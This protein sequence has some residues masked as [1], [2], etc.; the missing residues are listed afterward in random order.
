MNSYGFTR[1][2]LASRLRE[3][4]DGLEKQDRDRGNISHT[5]HMAGTLRVR[6]TTS[7]LMCQLPTNLRGLCNHNHNHYHS[8]H[9]PSRKPALV[10]KRKA[11]DNH[12]RSRNNAY[13]EATT[14]KE[15]PGRVRAWRMTPTDRP[16][17]DVT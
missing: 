10:S 15:E 3:A 11:K 17:K 2:N 5:A 4:I 1:R 14:T 6:H 13:G 12:H 8:H 16:P 7:P 9:F